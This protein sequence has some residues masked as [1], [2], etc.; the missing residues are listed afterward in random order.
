MPYADSTIINQ[1]NY[2]HAG[3]PTYQATCFVLLYFK[4]TN[5]PLSWTPQ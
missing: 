2:L 5:P 1:P 3:M 4:S